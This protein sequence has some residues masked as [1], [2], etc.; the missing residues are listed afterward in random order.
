MRFI[1]SPS[2]EQ[3]RVL[4]FSSIKRVR[5]AIFRASIEQLDTRGFTKLSFLLGIFDNWP[6][7]HQ[8]RGIQKRHTI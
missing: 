5:A 3:I 6:I 1:Q 2:I 4:R 8:K 7:L